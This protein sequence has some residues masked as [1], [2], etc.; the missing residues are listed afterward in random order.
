MGM[1]TKK[2]QLIT[3]IVILLLQIYTVTSNNKC[4]NNGDGICIACESG[5]YLLEKEDEN[6]CVSR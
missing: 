2:K 5:N 3:I 1:I 6:I 4:L